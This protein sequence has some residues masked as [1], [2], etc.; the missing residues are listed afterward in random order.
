MDDSSP[1]S[2]VVAAARAQPAPAPR[3]APEL[4]VVVP[5]FNE[6]DNV[7]ILIERLRRVLGNCDW[8]ATFVDDN[9]PDGTAAV[10]RAIGEADSRIRCI[11][12]I[13]R[14]GLAGACLEGVLASQARYIAIMDADLQHDDTLLTAMLARLRRGDVDLVVASRYC[15]GGSQAGLTTRRAQASRWSVVLARRLLKVDLTDSMSGFFMMR[16][17]LFDELAPALSTQGF[18]LLLDIAA[19]ARGRLR[20]AELPYTFGKRLYGQ[21]KLDAHVALDFA[22]LLLAKLTPD[23]I[24]LRFAL[25]CLVGLTGV[26]VHMGVLTALFASDVTVF[27]L[28]QAIATVLATAWNFTLNNAFTYRDQRLAGWR[29][30]GGLVRF[31]LICGV[32]AIANVG[33]ANAI[34]H[35]QGAWWFAGLCG[36]L[37]GAV[38]NY[39]VSSALVWRV[40]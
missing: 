15:E 2:P 23:A 29:F 39:A 31:E 17:E 5:T 40:R 35:Q 27:S 6:R 36:A 16:R 25:F 4:G 24:S 19:T 22:E 14:R 37:V 10:V 8:E 28:E 21:S 1:A 20:V 11:R 7:P 30:A 9:S 34:Y 12:R 32:G 26:A 33:I 18:K 13:G 3:A 38:W